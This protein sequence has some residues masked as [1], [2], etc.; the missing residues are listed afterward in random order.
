LA[1]PASRG[2]LKDPRVLAAQVHRMLADP[3]ATAFVE[4]FAGQWLFLRDLSR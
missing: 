4:N 1:R 2:R 3:R